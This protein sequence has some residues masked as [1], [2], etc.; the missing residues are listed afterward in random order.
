MAT[1]ASVA[2]AMAF[3]SVSTFSSRAGCTRPART[4]ANSFRA[5]STRGGRCSGAPTGRHRMERPSQLPPGV[6]PYQSAAGWTRCSG[7]VGLELGQ[8]EGGMAALDAAGVGVEGGEERPFGRGEVPE[9]EIEGL[10]HHREVVVPA[11]SPARRG[12]R[13]EPEG[14]D[15]S[16][17]F[18][19]G[20]PTSVRPSNSGRSRRQD[21]RTCRRPP[22]RRAWS[23][24]SGGSAPIPCAC[25]GAGRARPGKGGGISAPGR[26]RPTEGRIRPAGRSR[27]SRSGRR[28]RCPAAEC[29][30]GDGS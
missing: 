1:S 3:H 17:S 8:S 12:G 25:G 13:P 5:S 16:T 6:I 20:V 29:A 14:P 21:G 22:C 7:S 23:R 2:A 27:P 10:G 30:A 19:N 4:A 11:R 24:P 15:R 18:R 26:S 28:H 9:D